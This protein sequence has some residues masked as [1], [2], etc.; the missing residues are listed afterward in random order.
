MGQ[1]GKEA[2]A[3]EVRN[4][5]VANEGTFHEQLI[6]LNKLLILSFLSLL[7]LLQWRYPKITDTQTLD[8]TTE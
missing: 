2:T 1:K 6:R 5:G 7:L 8:D 4:A 3:G